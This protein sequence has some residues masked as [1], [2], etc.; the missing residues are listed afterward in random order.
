MFLFFA[1]QSPFD[2]GY[3]PHLVL[4]G[5]LIVLLVLGYI[6]WR[7]SAGGE[8]DY[9]LAARGQGWIVSSLTIMATFF[10]S[11]AMLGVPGNTY[12]E[13]VV[14]T[15]FALNVP[16][17]GSA[18]YV[19][20]SRISRIGRAKGYFTPADMISDY[21]NSPVTLR[22]LAALIGFLYAVP[23]VVLQIRAGGFLAQQMFSG[24]W[25]FEIGAT[26]L[27]L[28]AMVYIMFGGMRSVAWTDVIQGLLVI[29]GMLLGGIA[30]VAALGGLGGFFEAVANLPRRSLSL[31][32]TTA[33]WPAEKL[34]TVCVFASLGSMIQPAQ[35]MRYYAARST[36]T[37]RRSAVIFAV[38]LTACYLFGVILIGLGGQ[39]LYPL[40]EGGQYR[41][42]ANPGEG[43]T[44]VDFVLAHPDDTEVNWDKLLPH[45]SVGTKTDE[46]D[47]IMMVVLKEH[48]PVLLG[49]LG[50][51]IIA[52]L[53]VAI[54]AASMSTADSN[55]HA[56]SAVLTHDVWDRFV[57]PDAS[58]EE[59]KWVG[60][61]AIAGAT[62]LAL[63]LVIAGRHAE[64]FNPVA[65][66][67]PLMVL[68]IAFSS[69]LIPVTLDMLFVRRG[70]RAG[71]IAGT[72][73]G[74]A[75]VFLFSPFLSILT[76]NLGIDQALHL[77]S[78]TIDVGAWGLL[79]N[80]VVFVLVGAITRPPDQQR[81]AE[82]KRLAI[83][84]G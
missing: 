71:A 59:R 11:A 79:G 4:V 58:E 77:M 21:Y 42:E 55:L 54:A 61:C 63:L 27:A 31:P 30:V 8:E 84:P 25:S 81:V 3:T 72:I 12:K 65:M 6:G 10:S 40:Q 29:T 53:L 20:G 67:I 70:T 74:L 5:Y 48:L 50:P 75:I 52:L 64:R 32:G 2:L 51:L 9:Y 7:R 80:L 24:P 26:V 19:L 38:V 36:N 35:W 73:V 17:S 69:Q 83:A 22:L 82:Y 43:S 68:A 44:E 47:Q 78:N 33:S 34:F 23:Y 56:L 15:L 49:V 46:F 37:L 14:F 66:I 45:P 28:I 18:V 41:F 62:V 13:G 60:R 39:A 57:R 76:E 16:F 1:A